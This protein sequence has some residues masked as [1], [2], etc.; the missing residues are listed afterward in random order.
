MPAPRGI[1]EKPR[2]KGAPPSPGSMAHFDGPASNRKAPS[3]PRTGAAV[4]GNRK[5]CTNREWCPES[6]VDPDTQKCSGRTETLTGQ[7]AHTSRKAATKRTRN[8]EE[9]VGEPSDRPKQLER[10]ALTAGELRSAR[11]PAPSAMLTARAEGVQRP[12][13]PPAIIV[14]TSAPAD[15]GRCSGRGETAQH[16]DPE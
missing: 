5:L 4:A 13:A 16:G 11:W 3:T 2:R 15:C 9:P 10:G 6:L 14:P 8:N 1:S 7:A 12:P